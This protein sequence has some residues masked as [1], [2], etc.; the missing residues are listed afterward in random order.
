[1]NIL[2]TES[3]NGW[4]GQEIRILKEAEGMRRRGHTVFFAVATGGKLVARAREKGFTVLEVNFNKLYWPKTLVQLINLIRKEKIELINTHSSQDSWIG[5]IAGR[6]MG[7]KIIRTRH[8]STPNKGGLNSF[9]LYSVLA[10]HVVTTSE[11]A[12]ER[13][14]SLRATSIPTGVEVAEIT[15]GDVA[16]FREQYGIL[17]TDILAGSLCFVRSWKGICDLMEAARLTPEIKWMVIGGGYFADY[18]ARAEKLGIKNLIFTGHLDNPYTAAA[19]LDIFLL[20][21]T[22]Q[23]GL[24]AVLLLSLLG[25]LQ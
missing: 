24:S 22:A 13:I 21:S 25:H 17:E 16:A 15:V 11:V 20:L 23:G 19:S 9:L 18:K 10:D 4:G 3:S 5:A 7:C 14:G 1:M 2:H 12:K 8:L 6:L